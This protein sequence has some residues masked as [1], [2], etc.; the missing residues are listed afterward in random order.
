MSIALGPACNRITVWF[1]RLMEEGVDLTTNAHLKVK[2][3]AV[4]FADAPSLEEAADVFISL[5]GALRYQGWSSLDLVNAV[6]EKMD[7]NENRTWAQQPDG[8]YQHVEIA[9]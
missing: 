3:E 5:I 4:E 8:T 2:H 7:I 6:H 1:Q 9:Q